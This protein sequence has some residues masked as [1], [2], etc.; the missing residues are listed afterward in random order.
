[1]KKIFIII[2]SILAVSC[3]QQANKIQLLQTRI[4]SLEIKL[5]ET[6]KPGL[7][8]FMSNIQ[9]HHAKLWYAGQNKNWKLANFEMEEIKETFEDINKYETDRKEIKLIPMIYPPLDSVIFAIGQQNQDRF[10]SSFALLTNTCNACHTAAQFDFNVVKIPDMQN[11]SNQD[12]K[13]HNY[14]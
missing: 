11:F 10:N 8:E 3:N 1:M 4:D 14:K 13:P 6:Y 2:F 5:A 12:F 7:G 9:A